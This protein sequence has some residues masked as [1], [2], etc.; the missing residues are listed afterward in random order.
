MAE[1]NNL[2]LDLAAVRLAEVRF[3]ESFGETGGSDASFTAELVRAGGRLVW[4]DEAVVTESVP[5]AR[6]TRSWVLRR[7]L[8]EGNAETRIRLRLAGAPR[9]SARQR[10]VALARGA[11]RVA[12]G[13]AQLAAGVLGGRQ[14]LRAGGARILARER[15]WHRERWGTPSSS[16]AG[17]PP[18]ARCG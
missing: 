6:A 15:G 2:L 18:R 14:D 16:T 5:A 11:A 4:C 10:G 7:Q 3:D 13:S 12:G 8:R 1:T 17:H 9:R